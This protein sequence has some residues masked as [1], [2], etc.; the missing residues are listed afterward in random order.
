MT[1]PTPPGAPWRPPLDLGQGG[2]PGAAFRLLRAAPSSAW[3]VLGALAVADLA[4]DLGGRR[5]GVPMDGQVFTPATWTFLG[6]LAC[7]NSAAQ[8]VLLHILLTG[9]SPPRLDAGFVGFVL[10]TAIVA[11]LANAL[12]FVAQGAQ[13]LPPEQLLPR[14]LLVAAGGLVGTIVLTRLMLLPIA[15]LVGDPGATAAG[16]WGRMRGQ[17]LGFLM[18]SVILSLPGM[19]VGVVAVAAAGGAEDPAAPGVRIATQLMVAVL[20]ALG[21]AL[22]AVIYLRRVGGPQRLAD[23]FD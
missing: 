3:M 16:S 23:T 19:L 17:V 10:W 22:N 13:G 15:W 9:R 6:V 11:V 5:M 1:D 4:L 20:M 8:G 14:F 12:G 2:L 7:V 18:A 21:T